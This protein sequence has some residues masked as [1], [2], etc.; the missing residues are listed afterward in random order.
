MEDN[1]IVR[2]WG[3]QR[4]TGQSIMRDLDINSLSLDQM[5]DTILW[6]ECASMQTTPLSEKMFGCWCS[7]PIYGLYNILM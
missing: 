4:K 1:S 2:S 3:R 7:S 6:P 5:H